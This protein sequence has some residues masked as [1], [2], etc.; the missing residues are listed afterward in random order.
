M[1]GIGDRWPA[2]LLRTLGKAMLIDA[3]AGRVDAI[4]LPGGQSASPDQALR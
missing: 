1:R 3:V 4:R 2:R